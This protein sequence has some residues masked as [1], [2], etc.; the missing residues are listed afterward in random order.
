M[1]LSEISFEVDKICSSANA[2]NVSMHLLF[3]DDEP[4]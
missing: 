2:F 4:I 3:I 1:F